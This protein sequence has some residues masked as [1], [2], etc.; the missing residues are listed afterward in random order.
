MIL[1]PETWKQGR[2][3]HV[4]GIG[5]VIG[6]IVAVAVSRLHHGGGRVRQLQV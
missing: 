6:V 2:D 4:M 1:Q 5:R 3:H